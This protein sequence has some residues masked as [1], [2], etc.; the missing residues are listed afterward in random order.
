MARGSTRRMV[1]QDHAA[2]ESV[3]RERRAR[4]A[5]IVWSRRTVWFHN[6][7]RLVRLDTGVERPFAAYKGTG[8]Y[9]F[10]C[11]AH[12]DADEVYPELVRLKDAGFNVWYD[13][14]ISPGQTWRDE[15]ALALT[16]CSLFLYF[17]SPRSVASSNCQKEVNFC[18]S[19]ERKLLSVYLEKTA[20][21]AGLELSLSDR[22]AIVRVDHSNTAYHQ[23][24]TNAL[25]A[26]LPDV[27]RTPAVTPPSPHAADSKSI[28]ILPLANRSNDPDN[29][30]LC[31]GITEELIGG[32]ANVD[33]LRVASLISSLALKNQ[34]LDLAAMG[35]RLRVDHIL[36]GSVQ[37]AG[38]RVRI[39]F[40]LS[41]VD[42]G[43]SLWSKRYDR[44]V[45]D[46]FELQ[47][48]VAR[49]VVDALKVELATPPTE[50][51]LLDVGTKDRKAYDAFLL[52]LH[53]ARRGTR[54]SLERA[55]EHFLNAAR[56]D[57]DYARVYWWL[58]FCYWRLI[59]SGRERSEMERLGV[60]A[61]EKAEALG[62][63]PP[64]PWI[65]ARR[66]LIPSIRPDQRTLALEAC[67]KLRH[68]D[69]EWR[70]FEYVQFGECL[71]AAGFHHGACDYYAYY[72]A[73]TH[74]D[75]SATWIQLRYR[76]LLVQLG[77]YEQAA[78]LMIELGIDDGGLIEVYARTGQ[79]EKAATA[80]ADN[81]RASRFYFSR[82]HYHY[83]RRE[84]DVA[85]AYYAQHEE[86]DLEPIERYWVMFLLGDIERGLDHLEEDVRRGAH[87]AVFRSNI[88]EVIPP[89]I[90]R[91]IEQ[92]PRYRAIL[93]RFGIDE[94]WCAELKGLADELSGTTGIRVYADDEY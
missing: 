45:N 77:R 6:R 40:L 92:H 82:F 14:G 81:D 47:E 28:A 90:V 60:A 26:L 53:A 69:P 94:A 80:L 51:P 29:E 91:R 64:V 3:R 68:P 4:G 71:I 89:S 55:T 41:R 27:H 13:E 32:L 1:R 34:Q 46:I 48:D 56:L 87:P 9:I 8:P 62:F 83:W 57:P 61:L 73:H 30:Y 42:D 20:L 66:D 67:E 54:K 43:S 65:K 11:Y 10:V 33:G 5:S 74:H 35:E 79:Y 58:Y 19:R 36:S 85:R 93:Q 37:R 70:L 84:L 2:P 18:L 22:Q 21:P 25:T 88:G 39:M 38:N 24:L 86:A 31:D 78:A 50:V 16:Q 12:E 72:L 75:L 63:V 23:K 15:V 49:Q 52:G 17:V 7:G 44:E 76:S 59:G